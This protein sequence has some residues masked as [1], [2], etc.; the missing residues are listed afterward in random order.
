MRKELEGGFELDDERS[1]VDV[2]EVHRFLSTEAYWAIGRPRETVERLVRES[3]RVIGVYAPDGR[4]AGF[5]RVVTDGNSIAYLAD[6]YVHPDFRG[7]GLGAALVRE[8]VV[9]GPHANVRWV[10]HTN[11]PAFY[12]PFG[13]GP[14]PE[15]L[16]ERPRPGAAPG[17][18]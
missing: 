4:Q 16:M 10:L 9:E 13:F 6:V 17:M 5:C 2:G 3:T 7:R 1:R 8:A 14:P 11:D 18:P 15:R 12:E